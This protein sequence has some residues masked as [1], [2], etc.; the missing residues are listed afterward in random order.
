MILA[1]LLAGACACGVAP[2]R[3]N[4]FF[5]ENDKFGMRAYGPGNTHVWSGLDVFNKAAGA[6]STCGYVLHNH[7]KCGNWH[8]KPYKGILDNY[9]MGASRGVGGVALFG[10]GEWKTYPTWE[11]S[12]IVTNSPDVCEFKLV[13]PAFSAL[14]RMTYHIT[15]RKGER[16]FRND[17]SF[18]Y[19]RRIRDFK[20]GPGLDLEPKR[21]HRGDV[22]EDRDLGVVSLFEVSKNKTEGS[23]MSAIIVPRGAWAMQADKPEFMTDMQNCRVVAV[24][25][26][27][28][29]YYAGAAWSKAGGVTTAAEWH[30]TVREF[31]E[32]I[33][34]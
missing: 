12:E 28:F 22:W 10:D 26:P 18:E 30:K 32:R 4:D 24:G 7:D 31:A 3:E 17:V 20:V 34:K 14:G 5:W 6:E 19:P 27:A 25:K 1:A 21:D 29:T 23:S 9:T 33:N 13:Y 15:L 16:F 11:Q 2:E 8:L